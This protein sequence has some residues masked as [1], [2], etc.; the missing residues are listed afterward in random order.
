MSC[1]PMQRGRRSVIANKWREGEV[2]VWDNRMLLHKRYPMDDNL[3]RFMWRTQT[4][5]EAVVA[6]G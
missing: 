3:E 2:V 1:G 5:G 4:K 6:A